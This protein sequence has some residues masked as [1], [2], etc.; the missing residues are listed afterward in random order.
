MKKTIDEL[1]NYA[2]REERDFS[3][4]LRYTLKI[5][6]LA[7]DNPELTVQEIKDIIETQVDY[8]KGRISELKPEDL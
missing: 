6:L 8:E 3:S 7:L 1:D 4:A 5:G 2:K